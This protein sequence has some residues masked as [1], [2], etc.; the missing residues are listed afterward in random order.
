MSRAMRGQQ[1]ACGA[2]CSAH[3]GAVPPPKALF[4][5]RFV[6][7]PRWHSPWCLAYVSGGALQRRHKHSKPLRITPNASAVLCS[8]VPRLARASNVV[9]AVSCQLGVVSRRQ[10]AAPV[11][12]SRGGSEVVNFVTEHSAVKYNELAVGE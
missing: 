11:A 4:R 2:T 5:G 1:L 3:I 8:K 12:A 7:G 9:A 6:P 10:L